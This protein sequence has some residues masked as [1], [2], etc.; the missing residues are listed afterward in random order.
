MEGKEILKALIKN[1]H[2]KK[3]TKQEKTLDYGK[4]RRFASICE[5]CNLSLMYLFAFS[6]LLQG[7]HHFYYVLWE[8]KGGAITFTEYAM[9]TGEGAVC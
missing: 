3:K 6:F 2:A 7:S 5:V 1:Y 4:T 9:N 8:R